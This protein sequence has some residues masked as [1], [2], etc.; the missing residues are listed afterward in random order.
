MAGECNLLVDRAYQCGLTHKSVNSNHPTDK[1]FDYVLCFLSYEPHGFSGTLTARG[2]WGRAFTR[3]RPNYSYPFR[4]FPTPSMARKDSKV[5]TRFQ[6][7]KT[8]CPSQPILFCVSLVFELFIGKENPLAHSS[9]RALLRL[10][11]K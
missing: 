4:I 1:L 6:T 7:R 3:T 11:Y 10:T 2:L 9:R 8:K 5:L